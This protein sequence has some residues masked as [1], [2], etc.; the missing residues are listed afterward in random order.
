MSQGDRYR[1]SQGHE[2]IEIARSGDVLR[3]SRIVPDWPF[4][5]PPVDMDR[6]ELTRMP[7][8]YLLGAVPN[9]EAAF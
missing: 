5:S 8:R 1:D 6:S 3:V 7:S 9:Q 4:P 2:Y